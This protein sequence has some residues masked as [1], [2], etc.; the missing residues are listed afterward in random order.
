MQ[1]INLITLACLFFLS[2][3]LKA[4]EP[5][6]EVPG[7]HFSL[8]GSLDLFQKSATLE[9]FEQKINAK[10][11]QVNNLDLNEDGEVDYISV[12][13][14]VDGDIHAIVLQ[15]DVN[16]KETQDIAVIEVEKSGNDQAILQMIGSDDLYGEGYIVEPYDSNVKYDNEEYEERPV[17]NVYQ[18]PSI[19]YIYAPIYRPWVSPWRYRAHPVW[20]KPWRP[21]SYVTFRTNIYRPLGFHP[22]YNHR[23]LRAHGFYAAKKHS[24]PIVRTRY[25]VGVNKRTHTIS[26][27]KTR[28]VKTR[29][30]TK[31]TKTKVSKSPKGTHKTKTKTTRR[32]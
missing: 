7:D 14:E 18:W 30:G 29:S 20:W 1:K 25:S 24:S 16:D 22:V 9:E 23:V 8:E 12:R 15:V 6:D 26:A 27:S 11:N 2:L 28:T 32:S 4:Q 10:D 13:D 17:V 3:S 21:F 31:T 19:R 5:T